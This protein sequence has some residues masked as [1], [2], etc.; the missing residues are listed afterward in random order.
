MRHEYTTSRADC[1]GHRREPGI[2]KGIAIALGRAGATVYVTGRTEDETKAAVPLPGT[3]HATAAAVSAAGGMGIAVRCDHT[4]EKQA[5]AA[6]RRVIREQDRID[7][8]VNNAWRGYEG[9]VTGKHFAPATPSGRSRSSTGTRTWT[10]RWTY[11]MTALTAPQMVKQGGGIVVN[12]TF[13]PG[14]VDPAY[15]ASKAA[16]DRLTAEFA[17]ALKP[18]QVAV[19]GLYPGLVRTE[20]VLKN[21]RW[22]DMT[23]SQSPEFT[24]RAV[25][26]LAAD[27]A[28][29]AK[30]GASY[31]VAD[32][33]A[34]YGFQDDPYVP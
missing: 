15:G 30:S 21:A 23:Q 14:L 13:N 27:P 2:G 28:R 1:A 19:M 31:V 22:F 18:H 6:V 33:S 26:A 4:D 25:A 16:V 9:Y 32:L 20:N 12:I 3:I 5:K 24:G 10:A 29:M 11:M 17:Q 8:L 34:E 7:I